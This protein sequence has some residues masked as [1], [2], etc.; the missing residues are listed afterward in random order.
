MNR[1]RALT[2]AFTLIELLV[3]IAI[4]AILAA[5]L[6]PVFAQAKM[7]AKKTKE[8]SNMKQIGTAAFLYLADH[9]DT[10]PQGNDYAEWLWPFLYAPYTKSTPKDWTTGG[11]DTI[12]WSPSEAPR[13]QYLAGFA[14]VNQVE[15][16]GLQNDFHLQKVQAPDGL[17]AYAF[18]STTSI[19][20]SATQEWPAMSQYAEPAETIFFTQAQD[21]EV[22]QDEVL[23][24]LGRHRTCPGKDGKKSAY[25]EWAPK[26][27][28]QEGTTWLWIDGHVTYRK[29]TPGSTAEG[30]SYDPN[31]PETQR[32]CARELWKWPLG[33]GS[34]GTN[35]CR[36]W[37]APAD[38]MPPGA[39]FGCQPKS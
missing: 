31:D 17:Q 3:V 35:N 6:F 21:T 30:S 33:G 10:N 2:K 20:E 4:I 39:V 26:G 1:K 18:W 27:G 38:E 28:Y 19:N 8:I 25:E 23:E 16:L 29:L 5:I 37:S 7:A 14:R 13:P 22:E 32:W 34:G 9:D 11:K 36:E 12:F 24:I 15:A